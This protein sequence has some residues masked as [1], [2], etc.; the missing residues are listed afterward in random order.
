LAVALRKAQEAQAGLVTGNFVDGGVVKRTKGQSYMAF[1]DLAQK[2]TFVDKDSNASYASALER[3][4]QDL[5]RAT[6]ADTHAQQEV[7]HLVPLW[8]RSTK[9]THAGIFFAGRIVNQADKG[10]VVEYQ[11]DFGS[12]EPLTVLVA[13]EQANSIESAARPLAVLGWMVDEPVKNIPGYTGDAS[14]AVWAGHI[15]SLE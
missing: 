7:A 3:E 11:V 12:G 6:L 1:C 2:A 4:V 8:I 5:V 15:F 10:A 14:Q 9:R 13:Q